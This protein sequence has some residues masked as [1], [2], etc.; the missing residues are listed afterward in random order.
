MFNLFKRQKEITK[1]YAELPPG[2]RIAN[3]FEEKVE[4]VLSL[5]G[6]KYVKSRVFFKRKV[7]QLTHEISV[8]KSKWNKGD[9]VCCFWL[10]FSSFNFFNIYIWI[11]C[12]NYTI[13]R[14]IQY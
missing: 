1:W 10:V 12:N 13:F 3:L 7:G 9:K 2:E 8:S 14:M 5:H 6:Y 11:A 4:P